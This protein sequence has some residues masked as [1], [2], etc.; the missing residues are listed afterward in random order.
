MQVSGAASDSDPPSNP[1]ACM[2]RNPG[3]SRCLGPP[4][5]AASE[6]AGRWIGDNARMHLLLVEDDAMLGES[7]CGALKREAY[8]VDWVRDGLKAQTALRDRSF[9]AVLLDLGLPRCDGLEVLRRLR[10]DRDAT[11]V[12]ILTARDQVAE[13]VSGLDSGADDYL[14]KPFDLDELLARLRVLGRRRAGRV[15]PRISHLGVLVD[16]GTREVFFNA[17]PVALTRREYALLSALLE[18]PGRVWAR[19]ELLRRLYPTGAA[20]HSNALE[21]H[22][23]ALRKKLS[24]D[25]I[26]SARGIGYFVPRQP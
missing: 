23:H 11:P 25:L 9:D 17:V 19:E 2:N 26:K 21:V 22:I 14:V 10:A 20:V 12:L 18:R 16:P 7:L 1:G 6:F 4:A 13:R 5:A 24:A 15:D 8:T 3:G